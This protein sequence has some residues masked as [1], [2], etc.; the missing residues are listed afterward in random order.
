MESQRQ[1]F[2]ARADGEM[3]YPMVILVNAGSASA[4]EIVAGALQ[5]QHRA[6]LLGNQ[7][8][9]KGSV[10]TVYPLED[11]SGLRLT[12]AL[13]YTPAGRSIQEVG[14]EPDILV[15]ATELAAVEE[16]GA[17]PRRLR[18]RDLEGHFS[19]PAEG[20]EEP[21]AATEPAADEEEEDLQLARA[22]EVLKSWTYFERLRQARG[23][24]G[25]PVRAADAS[26]PQPAT[27]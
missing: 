23:T 15:E 24:A 9:G 4:S 6:L 2:R 1:E 13:Y 17:L 14:I 27:P 25:L 10:Q 22:V 26:E 8:F 12:T 21:V 20:S 5:D 19:Q 7:T 18:E 3:D 16:Q 11:G